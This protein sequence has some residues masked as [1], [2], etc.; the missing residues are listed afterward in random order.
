M[1]FY[2]MSGSSKGELHGASILVTV[3][4]GMSGET[5]T[6]TKDT[7]SKSGVL[8]DDGNCLF[9]DLL[10]EGTYT[11]TYQTFAA[12]VEVS[13]SDV[14]NKVTKSVSI[15]TTTKIN[16][17]LEGAKEDTITITDKNGKSV[18]VCVFPTGSTVGEVEIG[19]VDGE[20]YTFTSSIAKDTETGTSDYSKTVTLIDEKITTPMTLVVGN[21]YKFAG[22]DWTCAEA[23]DGGYCLQSQGVTS[24]YW[25]GYTLPK[26]GNGSNYGSN[27][28][29]QDMSDYDDVTKSLYKKIKSAE[30]NASYGSGLFIVSNAKCGTTINN[31][32]GSGNYWSAIVDAALKAGSGDAWLG[33]VYGSD[34][35]WTVS[36]N[37]FLFSYYNQNVK[38]VIAPAFNI[39]PTKAKLV[40][41]EIVIPNTVKVMPEG[42]LYWYGNECTDVTGG[43]TNDYFYHPDHP[44]IGMTKSTNS[45]ITSFTSSSTRQIRTIGTQDKINSIDKKI[46]IGMNLSDIGTN[47]LLCTLCSDKTKVV[48]SMLEQTHYTPP[49]N[50]NTIIRHEFSLSVESFIAISSFYTWGGVGNI[51]CIFLE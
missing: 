43:W 27:I 25:P 50:T 14:L 31:T 20:E 6:L 15:G 3:D 28:D 30:K 47:G 33:T 11:A 18:G 40:G 5:V 36:F 41:N 10:E 13:A 24:G 26:W 21:T 45:I 46:C 48:E 1:A 29:G 17:I 35:A 49:I 42:A 4:G 22:Y 39:D 19:I 37:T 44:N 34:I 12:D 8:S 7:F 38:H 51:Q 2:R 16:L 9:T 32:K 23:I